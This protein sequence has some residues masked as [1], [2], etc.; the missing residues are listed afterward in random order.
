MEALP[1]LPAAVPHAPSSTSAAPAAARSRGPERNL[2]T[3]EKVVKEA[4]ENGGRAT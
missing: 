1:G 4:G 3:S 2:C